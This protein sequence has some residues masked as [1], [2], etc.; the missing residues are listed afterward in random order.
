MDLP[1]RL[2]YYSLGR[3]FVVQRAQK[4]DPGMVD[5]VGSDAN[6]VIGSSAVLADAV[7][8]Q[9]GYA[10]SKLTLDG[11]FDEDLDRYA[12]DRYQIP[13]KGASPAVGQ[14]RLYRQLFTAGA[15]T[16]PSGTQ[17]LTLGSTAY[18]TTQPASFGATTL[19]NVLVNVRAV[20]AGKSTQVGANQI[21]RFQSSSSLFDGTIQVNNDLTTGGGEDAEDD[22]TLKARV[23]SFWTTAQRG[24][25]A[26]IQFGALTVP[27]VVSAVAIEALSPSTGLPAR[28]VTLFISD[29]SG[30]A[31]LPLA[32]QVF[33]VLDNYRAAGIPV[34]VV[35]SIPVL[36]SIALQL[37]FAPGVD[38]V[39]LSNQV[40]AAI[41]EF[42]NSLPVNGALYLGQLYSVLQRFAANGLLPSQG[43]ILAPTGDVIPSVGQTI[44]TMPSL[45]TLN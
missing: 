2:D 43:N 28:A 34:I 9:L 16:V 36:E 22:D 40:Q 35:T 31:S 24:T 12:W 27:G 5:V 11:C 38:T 4:I 32:Q 13:R 41:V 3:Q 20:Q 10:V 37:Q 26:A 44:R 17:L 21:Q 25:L 29:S 39:T 1:S 6:L 14:V 23:R 15:G 8:K 18:V 7:T 33:A 42:V 19:D 45:V 30:V